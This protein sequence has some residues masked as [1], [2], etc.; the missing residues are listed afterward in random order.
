M[1]LEERVTALEALVAQYQSFFSLGVQGVPFVKTAGRQGVMTDFWAKQPVGQGAGLS[2]G[3]AIDRFA[4]YFEIDTDATGHASC[5]NHPSTAVYAAVVAPHRVG[6]LQPNI[7]VEAHAANAPAGNI[8]FYGTYQYAPQSPT[9]PTEGI[10]LA[11]VDSTGTILR[12][13]SLSANGI[14]IRSGSQAAGPFKV[15]RD[16]QILATL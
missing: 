4:G 10:R 3:T 13:V 12:Q 9:T 5:P 1:T 11:E 15:V 14:T 2:V 8:P 6:E 7:G 16:G